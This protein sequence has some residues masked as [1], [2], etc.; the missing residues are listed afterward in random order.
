MRLE[1]VIQRLDTFDEILR[2]SLA[3]Q[4]TDPLQEVRCLFRI[5]DCSFPVSGY[6]SVSFYVDSELIAQRRILIFQKEN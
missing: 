2:R 6:Y 5:R 3:C 4:F 1:G